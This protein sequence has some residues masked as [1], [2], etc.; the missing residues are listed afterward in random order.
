LKKKNDLDLDFLIGV[1][2][3]TRSN[4]KIDI[5]YNLLGRLA[6]I[7]TAEF[8][9]NKI[10][11]YPKPMCLEIGN[12]G[13]V[14]DYGQRG[15]FAGDPAK[16]RVSFETSFDSKQPKQEPK[17]VS[18]LSETKRLFRLFRFNTET[19]SFDVSICFW[20]HDTNRNKPETDLVSV[21]FGSNRNFFVCFEDT[22]A[23]LEKTQPTSS[24]KLISFLPISQALFQFSN[25]F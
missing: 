6:N 15:P 10:P 3:C 12:A 16:G 8:Y 2:R 21:C 17:L 22:L 23:S 25:S 20:F 5:F 14:L 1:K 24:K 4:Y 11:Y 13:K 19:E 7:K 9:S 18:A